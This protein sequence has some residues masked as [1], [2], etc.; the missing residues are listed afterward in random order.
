MKL[1][2]LEIE[3]A[4]IGTNEVSKMYLGRIEINLGGNCDEQ[5]QCEQAGGTWIEEPGEPG[6]CAGVE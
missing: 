6:Y 3:K 4:Y 2:Q 1:G 5:C